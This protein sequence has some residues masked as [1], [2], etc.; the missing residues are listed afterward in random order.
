MN[1]FPSYDEEH[2][3]T[4]RLYCRSLPEDHRRRYAAVDALKIG[5][6]GIASIAKMLGMS[7]RTI[8]SGIRE[9]ET[10][11]E[12]DPT[13]P[14]RRPSGMGR[15]RR[16]G[17]G[18]P[19]VTQRQ[20]GL[21]NAAACVLD[22]HT[23]GRP[24]DPDVDWTHL[25]P[26]GLA[27]ALLDW[28]HEVSRQT[29]ARLMDWAGDRRRAL[30]KELIIG[31]VDPQQ[32]DQ[33]FQ[34][35][36]QQRREQQARGT[37]VLC[38]DTK[39]KERLGF[40]HRPGTCDGTATQPV[41]DH[42]DPY[43][44]TGVVVPHGVYDPVDNIGFL[45]LGTSR[46]TSAFV[47]DAIALAWERQFCARYPSA[48]ELFLTFDAGG[49]NA[50][51]SWRF[52]EDLVALSRRL[53]RRLR[54][55]HDPPDTSKW[56]PIEHRLF[57]QV[58]RSLR[59]QILDTHETALKA[60]QRTTTDTGLRVS[61]CILDRVYEV[62]R[63]CSETFRAIKDRFIRHDETLEAWNYVVDANGFSGALSIEMH[64]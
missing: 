39:H 44:A 50:V 51:R 53:A 61:A 45:T 52:K 57:S 19:K 27:T 3:R 58:E 30:R 14:P 35:V 9:L 5:H 29:A 16:R 32:R 56:H 24:T 38:V 54:I 1:P 64:H 8:D 49:A 15:I 20:P 22:A 17:G 59:G 48:T 28:G 21:E 34:R 36:A 63:K 13:P 40:L 18:R 33:Q 42:D 47:C 12:D 26:A 62:G 60:V 7:R 31:H 43:L 41:Y 55:A 25:T 6:G 37:P 2:E 10:M 23:A 46:E 11:G 4:M